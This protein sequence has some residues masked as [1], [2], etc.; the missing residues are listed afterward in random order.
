MSD[1]VILELSA[2]RVPISEI[3]RQIGK[4]HQFV[5]R[6]LNA[7]IKSDNIPAVTD[8]ESF[9]KAL[10]AD[11]Q[12]ERSDPIVIPYSL[13][14]RTK[15]DHCRVL[16]PETHVGK[17]CWKPETGDDWD[18]KIATER[19]KGAVTDILEKTAGLG[20]EES[21]L[22]VGNDLLQVDSPNNTTT[23][24]TY[25]DTDSR[26]VRSFRAARSLMSWAIKALGES[27]DRVIVKIVPGNHDRVTA[28]HIGEVLQMEFAND[29]N[30]VFNDDPTLRQ[31]HEYGVNL[32]GFT[33]GS[34][35]KQDDLPQLM[36]QEQKHAWARTEHRE[37]LTGHFHKV[38]EVRWRSADT[39]NGVRV[40]TVDAL[41]TADAWHTSKGYVGGRAVLQTFIY[42]RH[43]GYVG[44]FDSSPLK[45]AA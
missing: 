23:G 12:A 8:L 29:P 24:G 27:S 6:R 16:V 39:F 14:E 18:V 3:G 9:R 11:I 41:C 19:F 40:R 45:A 36:A 32:L 7:L 26:Y 1:S 13:P 38:K 35:E 22:V 34:E 42:N 44:S 31:Y 2:K 30:V 25:V 4:N 21:L 17:L 20:F 33:H 10:I 37:W 28:F 5:R 43:T 15:A